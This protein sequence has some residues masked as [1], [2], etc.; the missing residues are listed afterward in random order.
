MTSHRLKDFSPLNDSDQH[1]NNCDHKQNMNKPSHGVT[2][3][4]TQ[5]PQNYQYRGNC[6]QHWILLPDCSSSL[7]RREGQRASSL[8]GI[9]LKLP[10]G[11]PVI[12]VLH[13]FY[14]IDEFGD[15]VLSAV[16]LPP[17]I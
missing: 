9:G 2:A 14:V 1:H 10:D 7:P 11:H 13:T 15:Q 5:E 8:F 3:H 4:Q 17:L 6:P 12:D 16:F